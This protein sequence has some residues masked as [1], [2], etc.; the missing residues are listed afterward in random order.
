MQT[1]LWV[2]SRNL[3]TFLRAYE[4]LIVEPS[5]SIDPSSP[6]ARWLEWAYHADRLDPL[7][8]DNLKKAISQFSPSNSDTQAKPE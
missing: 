3:R 2:K 8:S 1:E 4:E 6:E 7:K 5:G